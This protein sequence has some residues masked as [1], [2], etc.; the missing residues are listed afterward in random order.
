MNAEFIGALGE[1]ERER[2]IQKEVLLE[3]IEQAL[4]SAYRRN[5]GAAQNVR[6]EINPQTGEIRVLSLRTVTENPTDPRLES[7]LDEAHSFDPDLKEGD[8]LTVEVTP[9]DFGRIAAQT[10]KQVV[11]QRIREAERGMVFEEYQG[12][13][14]DIVTGA[15]NR[16]E[17][18][19]V[20]ID[21]GPKAE[22]LLPPQEQIPDEPY[23]PGMRLK[24]Y[25]LEVK[26]TPRG[27]E[28]YLSRSHPG[29][30]KRLLELEV[31]E[32]HDGLVEV[33]A[34]AREAGLRSKVAVHAR[35]PKVDPVGAVIGPKG[36][37]INTVI[38]E[39][40]SEKVDVVRWDSDPAQLVANALSP[41]RVSRVD[42]DEEGR[43]A[44]VR[45]PK[46]H[47]SLAIGREGQNARLAHKLTGYR[48]DIQA[49]TTEE[50]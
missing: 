32:V 25:V 28:I 18:R 49:E 20:F 48:V 19:Q 24:V 40:R 46:N 50:S 29:L 31:P 37:R 43:T 2:G 36:S 45:V 15:V 44:H 23:R 6:V 35:D 4:V 42:I 33:R 21:L 12:R 13:E 30:L 34:V 5:F 27:P 14:G 17:H 11:V 10:A 26:R 1:I 7:S 22:G 38:A 8:L 47:L 9:R 41:A 16:V 3:A 39:L